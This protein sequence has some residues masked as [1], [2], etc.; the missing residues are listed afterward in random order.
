LFQLRL[1]L[2][3]P[4]RVVPH[5]FKHLSNGAQ[6]LSPSAVVTLSPLAS[7]LDESRRR[8]A[9]KLQRHGTKGD[10]RH[11]LMN[12]ARTQFAIPHETKDFAAA[13]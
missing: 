8:Q 12:G 2:E 10:V 7:H 3:T 11:C 5:A 4:E 6:R 13:R 1:Q 9:P